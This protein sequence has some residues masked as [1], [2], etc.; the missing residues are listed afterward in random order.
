[1]LLI[2]FFQAE[3]GI[4][5]KLVTGVQTCALP[6]SRRARALS[7]VASQWLTLVASSKSV[8]AG[9]SLSASRDGNADCLLCR[10]GKSQEAR[11]HVHSGNSPRRHRSAN[12]ERAQHHPRTAQCNP[13][14]S[15]SRGR[16][17]LGAAAPTFE[18][19]SQ[20]QTT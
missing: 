11:P 2:F 19:S 12:E 17:A 6:I 10:H 16:R 3:D 15:A 18:R 14:A 20:W 1:M 13:Q 9:Y 7:K 5:D 4:R 8:T